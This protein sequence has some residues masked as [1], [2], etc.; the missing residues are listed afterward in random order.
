M[1][2]CH[3]HMKL[4][5]NTSIISILSLTLAIVKELMVGGFRW[6]KASWI[7]Q[8]NWL[9]SRL[10]FI[11]LY[12]NTEKLWIL[13][14]YAISSWVHQ[15]KFTYCNTSMKNILCFLLHLSILV[16]VSGILKSAINITWLV[17]FQFYQFL[18]VIF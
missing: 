15:H 5:R 10:T 6:F 2:P 18:R 4:W 3:F 14:L 11:N 8:V 12:M 13:C 1:G 7:R 17:S 9:S 16:S